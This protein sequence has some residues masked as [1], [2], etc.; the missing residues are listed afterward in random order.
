[1]KKNKVKVNYTEYLVDLF[2]SLG[3]GSRIEQIVQLQVNLIYNKGEV[4]N[5][6]NKIQFI[7]I[8]RQQLTFAVTANPVFIVFVEILQIIQPNGIFII[9]AT[10]LN[11]ANQF[12]DI[13]FQIN[14]KIRGF[15]KSDH[16]LKN[17]KIALII[18]ISQVTTLMKI[19]CKDMC[20]FIDRPILYRNPVATVYFIHLSEPA[21]QKIDLQV[22]RPSL[23]VT[24]KVTE[25]GVLLH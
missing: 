5:A 19:G 17:I 15:Y 3:A 10:L 8:Y 22:K 4:L 23:H 9:T 25:V 1:M 12:R 13:G 7:Y 6:F 11:L 2:K 21:V 16:G 20:I 24:I 18:L 14:Q